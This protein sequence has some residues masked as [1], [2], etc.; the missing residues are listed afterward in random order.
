MN[1]I[2]TTDTDWRID[3]GRGLPVSGAAAPCGGMI[4]RCVGGSEP[5]TRTRRTGN[6]P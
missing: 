3:C 1:L 4:D 6:T 2:L 5:R